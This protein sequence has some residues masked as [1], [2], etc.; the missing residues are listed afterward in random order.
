MYSDL[1]FEQLKR[2]LE[3][4]RSFISEDPGLYVN[5][6]GVVADSPEMVI[7]NLQTYNYRMYVPYEKMTFTPT[8]TLPAGVRVA[9][10]EP[11]CD[12]ATASFMVYIPDPDTEMIKQTIGY[13]LG[14][15]LDR[16]TPERLWLEIAVNIPGY[17]HE[18]ETARRLIE[19]YNATRLMYELGGD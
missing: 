7:Y 6:C 11:I 4:E 10:V 5:E 16:V 2:L 12:K 9:E 18:T 3:L 13:L 8:T 14:Q 19:R 17:L 15:T 1:A